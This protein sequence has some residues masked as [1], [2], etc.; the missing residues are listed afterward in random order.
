MAGTII[1]DFI[2]TDANKLS[3]NVGNTTFATINASGLFSNT[4]VQIINQNGLVTLVDGQITPAKMYSGSVIQVATANFSHS[5]TVSTTGIMNYSS[6]A[7]TVA[8]GAQ[9][10][11]ITFTPVSPSSTIILS[12]GGTYTTNAVSNIIT[13]MF[14]GSTCIGA[15]AP[16]YVTVG[17][18]GWST[19][20]QLSKPSNGTQ[21]YTVRFGMQNAGLASFL[22]YPAYT[23]TQ[24][25]FTIMEIKN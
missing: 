23:V 25:L 6:S 15:M 11:S 3:L 14:E 7:P 12:F 19:M 10:G 20:L 18:S 2:R 1:C 24:S 21:T 9:I 13:A 17:E 5:N 4:G 16:R 8:Q 22:A